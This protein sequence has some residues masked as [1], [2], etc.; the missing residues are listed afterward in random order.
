MDVVRGPGLRVRCAGAHRRRARARAH[1]LAA[2]GRALLRPRDVGLYPGPGHRLGVVYRRGEV[3][4]PLAVAIAGEDGWAHPPAALPGRDSS[5]LLA[6]AWIDGALE[7]VILPT[8]TGLS[9]LRTAAAVIVRL[10]D[11]E[12]RQRAPFAAPAELCGGSVY[13]EIAEARHRDGSWQL[14]VVGPNGADGPIAP[15]WVRETGERRALGWEA[16]RSVAQ[17]DVDGGET[18]LTR[19]L[20]TPRS[21]LVWEGTL[22]VPEPPRADWDIMPTWFDYDSADGR[23]HRR[24]SWQVPAAILTRAQR[25]GG[26]VLATN[27]TYEIEPPIVSVSEFTGSAEPAV[28]PVAHEPGFACGELGIGTFVER[29]G[30]GYAL[31]SDSGCYVLLDEDL[32]R[33]DPLPLFEHLERRGSLGMDWDESS[34]AVLLVW[35]LGGLPVCVV[36]GLLFGAWWAQPGQRRRGMLTAGAIGAAL[37]ALSGAVA[38]ARVLPLLS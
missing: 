12:L 4:G 15:W 30:G 11:G 20:P 2:A 5:R 18:G 8:R 31:V 26:R 25:V 6:G 36:V 38:L 14:A 34:H 1:P 10:E 7:L 3:N 9:D 16:A 22:A 27:S 19:T 32:G 13:C 23:I 21:R 35:T 24:A 28:T 37:F 33:L 17:E 29:P